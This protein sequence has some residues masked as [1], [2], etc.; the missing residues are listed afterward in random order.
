MSQHAGDLP[1]LLSS[2]SD[3]LPKRNRSEKLNV[4]RNGSMSFSQPLDKALGAPFFLQ[5]TFRLPE[6][7]HMTC[8]KPKGT[9]RGEEEGWGA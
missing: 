9:E 7:E 6:P 4:P 1:L 8:K 3:K 2:V 5:S